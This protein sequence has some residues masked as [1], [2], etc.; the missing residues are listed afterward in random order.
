MC[1]YKNIVEFEGS[2]L[3][4]GRGRWTSVENCSAYLQ[5]PW[6]KTLDRYGP[7]EWGDLKSDRSE[8]HY[9]SVKKRGHSFSDSSIAGRDL[10]I[11]GDR[12]KDLNQRC[13]AIAKLANAIE[14]AYLIN[15]IIGCKCKEKLRLE[16]I[17][18]RQRMI[19]G[20]ESVNY[21]IVRLVRICLV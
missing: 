19:K 13:D 20:L 3:T 7:W 5:G 21:E 2:P 16:R 8:S 4:G 1:I 17:W 14:I 6:R 12:K 11:T 15:L 18:S 9:E 10:G